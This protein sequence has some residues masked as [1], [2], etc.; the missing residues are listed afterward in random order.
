MK[1]RTWCGSVIET[2]DY[3]WSVWWRWA[4][5]WLRSWWIDR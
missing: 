1:L 4:E 2:R 3:D 5:G